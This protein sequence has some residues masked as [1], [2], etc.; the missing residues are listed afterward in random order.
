MARHIFFLQEKLIT[1]GVYAPPLSFFP[2]KIKNKTVSHSVYILIQNVEGS[3]VILTPPPLEIAF[4]WLLR[5]L[6]NIS[7][8]FSDNINQIYL[9]I[10]EYIIETDWGGG[11]V[12][13]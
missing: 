5:A 7:Y 13:Y 2:S 10:G 8:N 9:P 3:R 11:S 4:P 6:L 12:M 1:L